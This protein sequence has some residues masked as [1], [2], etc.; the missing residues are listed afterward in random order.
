[1]G[2]TMNYI[3]TKYQN[4]GL[5]Q[6]ILNTVYDKQSLEKLPVFYCEL[7]EAWANINLGQ[8]VH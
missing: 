5:T 2:N 7:L 1:M 3:L 6:E 8:D 4:I